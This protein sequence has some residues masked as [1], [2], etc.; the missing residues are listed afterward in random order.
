VDVDGGGGGLDGGEAVVV[1]EGVEELQVQDRAHAGHRLAAQRHRGVAH[2][3]FVDFRPAVEAGH[4]L[5]AV[6]PE[7]VQFAQGAGAGGGLEL[8]EQ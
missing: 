7:H 1:V 8:G 2:G 4:H 5:D 3:V 6:G